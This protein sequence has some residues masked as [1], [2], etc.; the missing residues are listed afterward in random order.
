MRIA[1]NMGRIKNAMLRSSIRL[2]LNDDELKALSMNPSKCRPSSIWRKGRQFH[3]FT[4][5]KATWAGGGW[6]DIEAPSAK[7]RQRT[8]ARLVNL[9]HPAPSQQV[10]PM[11]SQERVASPETAR[12]YLQKCREILQG[13]NV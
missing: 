7:L 3:L 12:I 1:N 4:G 5:A 6:W 8:L 10:I 11:P 2:Q 13:G 9:W